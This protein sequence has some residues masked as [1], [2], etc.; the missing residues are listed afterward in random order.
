MR[1]RQSFVATCEKSLSGRVG[2]DGARGEQLDR[3]D[4]E[5]TGVRRAEHDLGRVAGLVG[6]EP[7]GG[8]EAPAVAGLEPLEPV[9]GVRRREVVAGRL[10][11]LEELGGD[12]DADRVA[13]EILRAR[14]AAAVAVEA[15]ERRRSSTA[16]A[17]RR[18]R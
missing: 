11:E 8:A 15:G 1:T 17:R 2:G 3:D 6:L 9:L 14:R 18:R 13:A 7:A 16:A 4:V 10:A 12:D 5:R